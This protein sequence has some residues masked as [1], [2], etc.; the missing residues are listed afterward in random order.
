MARQ[1]YRW[2]GDGAMPIAQHFDEPRVLEGIDRALRRLTSGQIGSNRVE[3]TSRGCAVFTPR[4]GTYPWVRLMLHRC[5][6]K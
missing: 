6:A 1:A 3:S 2:H 4:R 5:L